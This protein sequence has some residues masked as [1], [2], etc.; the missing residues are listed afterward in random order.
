[1]LSMEMIGNL[2]SKKDKRKSNK[3]IEKMGRKTN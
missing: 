3:N 1:M 2:E